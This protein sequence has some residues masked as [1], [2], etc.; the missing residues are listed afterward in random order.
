MIDTLKVILPLSEIKSKNKFIIQPAQ[1]SLDTGEVFGEFPL[2]IDTKGNK[3]SGARAYYN[4]EKINVTIF[5]GYSFDELQEITKQPEFD[6]EKDFSETWQGHIMV[7]VSIPKFFTGSNV[8]SISKVETMYALSE[9]QQYLFDVVGLETDIF[10]SNVSR[11]DTF[12]NLETD[13][14]FKTYN[15]ILS[16]LNLK[17]KKKFEYAGTTF[18]Y[19]NGSGQVCIYDKIEEQ[20]NQGIKIDLNL[21]LMRIELRF[22]KSSKFKYEFGFKDLKTMLDFYEKIKEKYIKKINED[23]F[24]YDMKELDEKLRISEISVDKLLKFFDSENKRYSFS[25]FLKALS[26]SQLNESDIE[27][28]ELYV[29]TLDNKKR[30][31]Y[32]LSKLKALKFQKKMI[33]KNKNISNLKL[34]KELKDKFEIETEKY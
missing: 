8:K 7:Q 2:F 9:V 31:Y 25:N 12:V 33:E 4:D 20:K 23:V 5:P 21:N 34:Y 3:I 10:K 13:F 1:F 24:R 14:N 18:L 15:N 27:S 28:I 17:R 29:A 16:A 6:F 30:Q 26:F 32:L 11:I 22:L 19:K